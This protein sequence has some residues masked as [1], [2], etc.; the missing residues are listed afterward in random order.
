MRDTVHLLCDTVAEEEITKAI[1]DA[2]M[3]VSEY[4][5]GYRLVQEPVFESFEG[6]GFEPSRLWRPK[7]D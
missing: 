3:R 5:P 6:S 2:V 4:V 1:K 7:K